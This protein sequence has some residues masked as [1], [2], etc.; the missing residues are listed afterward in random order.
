[1]ANP[2]YELDGRILAVFFLAAAPFMAFGAYLVVGIA[3]GQLGESVGASLEQR[4][5][6]TKLSLE[7]YLGEQI[8]LLRLLAL[9][10]L[11]RGAVSAPPDTRNAVEQGRLQ[12]AWMSGGDPQ[13]TSHLVESTAAGRLR[14]LVS[15]RPAFRLV[16]VVGP[17]GQLV[18]STSRAGRLRQAD[19]A[20]FKA[21]SSVEVGEQA[22]VGDIQRL[23]GWQAG[24]L[25][26]VYP[27]HDSEG[28]L[29][30]AV[31]GLVDAGELYGVLAPVRVGRTGH[32]VVV[33]STDG[34]VLASDETE[35]ISKETFPGFDYLQGAIEGVA[36]GENAEALL[37]TT[38]E[39]RGYWTI[40]AVERK[41]GDGTKVRVEPSR[42]VGFTAVD[43]FPQ[44]RWMV[45]V[46]QDLDEALA[47]ISSVTRYLWLHFLGAFATVM[48]LALYFSFKVE[49]PVIDEA[50]HLHE[51]HVPAG[52]RPS[53][54]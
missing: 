36:Q 46:E 42:L 26:I 28:T 40:P 5:V 30:G 17:A 39:H 52:G 2:K 34:L 1:M 47:P 37:R 23:P 16:Q 38:S 7:R 51:E 45:I 50:L 19:E 13:A 21:V 8:I 29:L 41:S 27:I 3:K 4:A 32:A 44:I 18:A 48:L 25:E 22:F 24:M 53:E 14:Q 54:G 33:R 31:R 9:D 49:K 15:I 10:P 6:E 11:V 43:Q 20:W 12:K 35:R